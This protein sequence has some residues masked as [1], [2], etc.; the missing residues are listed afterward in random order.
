MTPP[1]RVGHPLILAED[2]GRAGE[3]AAANM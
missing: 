1:G 2:S 3:T